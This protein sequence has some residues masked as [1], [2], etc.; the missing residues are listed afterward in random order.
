M[1]IAKAEVNRLAVAPGE[2]EASLRKALRIHEDP[3]GIA[4]CRAG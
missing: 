1:L 4:P 2:A 3:A